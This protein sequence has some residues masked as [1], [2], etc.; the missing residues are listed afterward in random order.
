MGSRSLARLGGVADLD[1]LVLRDAE[2][3]DADAIVALVASVWSEYPGKTLVAARDM[4]EL[5][6]PQSAY[7]A[8]GGRFW[9]FEGADGSIVGTVAFRPA[10]EPGVVELQK[11]YVAREMRRHGLGQYLCAV[12]EREAARR[13]AIAVDLWSDVKL[14][15]AHRLYQRLGY[16]RGDA[17]KTYDDTSRTVRFYYRKELAD[18]TS[19]AA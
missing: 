6:R 18:E 13:G 3:A 1:C 9:V 5:L 4:P 11:L 10:A 8:W 12:V 14:V 16:A 15:D 2:D 7:A 17:L 19:I